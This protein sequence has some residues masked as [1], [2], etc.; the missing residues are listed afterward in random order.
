VPADQVTDV[1]EEVSVWERAALPLRASGSPPTRVDN[2]NPFVYS[3]REG[4]EAPLNRQTLSVYE[5]GQQLSLTFTERQGAN[6]DF[7]DGQSAKLLVARFDD[8][9]SLVQS[10]D[11]GFAL[12]TAADLFGGDTGD[13]SMAE[14]NRNAT[15]SVGQQDTITDGS[16]TLSHTPSQS[17]QYAYFLVQDREGAGVQVDGAGNISIS[18]Q[19]RI[20]G[21]ESVMVQQ[22]SSDVTL[23]TEDA[24]PGD[25]LSFEVDSNLGGDVTHV[26]L[27][28]DHE[29][30]ANQRMTANV[31]G[32]LDQ[33][34][35]ASDVTLEHSIS[36]V[37]GVRTVRGSP[38][39]LGSEFG[40]G[41]V[42]GVTQMTEVVDFLA[43]GADVNAPATEVRGNPST[44]D[45]SM[46]A[47]G[48]A[49][50]SPTLTVDTYGNWSTGQYRYVH[51][52][53]KDG[54][55]VLS[56]D[57]ATFRLREAQ[58]PTTPPPTTTPGDGGGGGGGGGGGDGGAP[59]RGPEFDM[60][61]LD[62]G[63][64]ITIR[65]A[66]NG[67]TVR[68]PLS[69]QVSGNGVRLDYLN[70]TTF[71]NVRQ[72]SIT[73]RGMSST[74]P[75]DVPEPPA[76]TA[77]SYFT[78]ETVNLPGSSIGGVEFQFSVSP[79]ALPSGMAPEQM[80]L[81]RYSGGEW[82]TVEPEYLG[83]GTYRAEAPGFSAWAV[84]VDRGTDPPGEAAFSLQTLDITTTSVTPGETV[85]VRTRVANDGNETGTY[86][87]RLAVNGVAREA[88][89]VTV[90]PGKNET[91]TFD[92]RFENP[93]SYE[94]TVNGAAAGTVEVI[95]QGS[96]TGTATSAAPPGGGGGGW[97]G[98]LA[99]I[100][101]FL[102]VAVAG[103]AAYNRYYLE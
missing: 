65:S 93:G 33:D 99:I 73:V 53:V 74:P 77:L 37:N 42:G 68:A 82:T 9:S 26:L 98:P 63:A 47:V 38:T 86:E 61:P 83:N 29:T 57:T 79:D 56:S 70:V 90:A 103:L 76:E 54:S 19:A 101:F 39:M 87:A 6:T 88:K 85:E 89:S 58:T 48:S 2:L 7:F 8:D 100:A 97:L 27:V 10:G 32:E 62:R 13:V 94:L 34:V 102:A 49:S 21:V 60:S 31:A 81:Y 18:G 40:D 59:D 35:Q 1:N 52:A 67:A 80:R 20:L 95:A 46:V 64:A 44:L 11:S 55:S 45:A 72:A 91:V 41:R 36:S 71:S 66:E 3:E 30:F 17:G 24:S 75:S 22:R 69:E 25:S 78:V 15:F 23:T 12:S 16:L 5:A 28:Y 84:G 50:S 4:I 43:E 14:I 92:L 51:L 96:V